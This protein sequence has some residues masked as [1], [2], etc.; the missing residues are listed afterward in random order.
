MVSI[1]YSI[2]PMFEWSHYVSASNQYFELDHLSTFDTPVSNVPHYH[3]NLLTADSDLF[4]V[5]EV[6]KQ[7]VLNPTPDYVAVATELLL[8]ATDTSGNIVIEIPF[9]MREVERPNNEKWSIVLLTIRLS[10]TS[11]AAFL[12]AVLMAFMSCMFC[13]KVIRER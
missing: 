3:R 2:Y 11:Q 4:I 6:G 7:S 1:D 9:S 10:Q 8:G 5:V 12:P 13:R